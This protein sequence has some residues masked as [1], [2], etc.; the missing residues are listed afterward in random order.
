MILETRQALYLQRLRYGAEKSRHRERVVESL[1]EFAALAEVVGDRLARRVEAVDP[2][3]DVTWI[4]GRLRLS[5]R[6]HGS[7]SCGLHAIG[8]E[9]SPE[10]FRR[11][12]DG[13]LDRA[14]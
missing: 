4:G 10:L 12:P 11:I 8:A 5:S 3:L 13:V 6:E 9:I 1:A 14:S 7:W 2:H